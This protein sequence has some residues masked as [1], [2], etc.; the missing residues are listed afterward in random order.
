VR[1]SLAICA[2]AL[3]MTLPI[4]TPST[5]APQSYAAVAVVPGQ[6]LAHHGYAKGE[7][8]GQARRGAIDQCS[9][10]R[11]TVVRQYSPGQCAHLV[12]GSSQIFWND[13]RFTATEKGNVLAYCQSHDK[14]CRVIRSEC[15][16][17]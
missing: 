13:T 5:A 4:T 14:S 6:G 16:P 3:S 15:L 8:A 11:C 10:S 12:V 2:L 7:T 9:D 1:T 17:K